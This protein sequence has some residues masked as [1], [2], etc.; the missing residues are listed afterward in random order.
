MA[1]SGQSET[2]QGFF[3]IRCQIH[4]SAVTFPIPGAAQHFSFE[5]KIQRQLLG[6][7]LKAQRENILGP[8]VGV[9]ETK[10]P[11]TYVQ[12]RPGFRLFAHLHKNRHRFRSITET[13]TSFL[14]SPIQPGKNFIL[15]FREQTRPSC[16]WPDSPPWCWALRAEGSH[17]LWPSTGRGRPL[18]Q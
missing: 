12:D 16:S 15:F 14:Q 9:M 7:A 5:K 4:E 3:L 10:P 2:M 1:L 6:P 13:L 17:S 11:R 8:Q 18:F